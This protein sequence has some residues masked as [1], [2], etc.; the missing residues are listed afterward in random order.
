MLTNR[1]LLNERIKAKGLKKSFLAEQIGKKPRTL[2]KKL[3]GTQDFTESEMKVL[4][5]VL[6]LTVEERMAIFFAE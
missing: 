2:S 3:K 1:E 6:Q 5:R 4:T